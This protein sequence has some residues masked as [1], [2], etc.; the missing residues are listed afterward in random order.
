MS[1]EESKLADQRGKFAQVVTDGRKVPDIEW[2]GGRLLLSNKRLVLASNEGKRTFPLSKITSIKSQEE[3]ANPLAKVDSYISVQVGADVMLLSPADHA[4]FEQQLYTAVLDQQ[5]IA[6]KHPA[7]EGGVVQDASWSK[8]QLTLDFE[9]IESTANGEVGLA[10]ANGQFVEI[11]INDVGTVEEGEATVLG[12]QRPIIEVSHTV[13]ATA[14]ETHIAGPR[15]KMS[16]L[17]ALLR[18]GEAQN[19][20]DV[21]LSEAENAVLMALYSGVSPFQIPDFIGMDVE[22]VEAIYD[23]LIEQ[24]ILEERRVRREVKLKARGRNIA[25]EA[26]D[27]E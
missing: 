12:D 23:Q 2:V 8:G 22:Q 17:G 6:V 7:V 14:V 24:G 1:D 3:A 18:K 26:M 10:V 21:E 16:I 13:E 9:G 27:D 15:H 19:T 5:V 25:T 11:E 4:P 20:T